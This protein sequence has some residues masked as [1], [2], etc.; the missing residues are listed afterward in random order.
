M[1]DTSTEHQ[2][3]DKRP[4]NIN[5]KRYFMA[6]ANRC[7]TCTAANRYMFIKQKIGSDM[8]VLECPFCDYHIT[9]NNSMISTNLNK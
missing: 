6:T 8:S 9:V 4:L 2:F 1:S 7:T 5:G 3:E